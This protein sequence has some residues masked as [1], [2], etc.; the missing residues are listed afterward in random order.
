M[1]GLVDLSFN[2]LFVHNVKLKI[3]RKEKGKEKE[4]EKQNLAQLPPW[5]S[6]AGPAAP[7]LSPLPPPPSAHRGGP[8]PDFS[9]RQ[10]TAP[11]PPPPARARV[12]PNQLRG[13]PA[14]A[15]TP[16]RA[17][18]PKPSQRCCMRAHDRTAAQGRFR[19]R[20]RL[21]SWARTPGSQ[22]NTVCLPQ[23]ACANFPWSNRARR[24]QNQSIPHPSPSFFA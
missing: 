22:A 19:A 11:T 23:T 24:F 20:G 5:P 2:H 13:G 14:P 6:S 21:F 1:N 8:A 10:P 18:Q 12:Q 15:P 9:P 3:N 17:K 7:S 16:A 4:K